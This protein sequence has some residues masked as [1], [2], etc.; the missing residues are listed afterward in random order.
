MSSKLPNLTGQFE[1]KGYWWLPENPEKK[2]PGILR[3]SQELINLE[4][5]GVFESDANRLRQQNQPIILGMSSK[6]GEITLHR[7][8]NLGFEESIPG[9]ITTNFSIMQLFVGKNFSNPDEITFRNITIQYFQLDDWLGI[10]GLDTDISGGKFSA[11]YTI[12]PSIIAKI[13]DEFGISIGFN[14]EF[15]FN[16]VGPR[17]VGLEQAAAITVEAIKETKFDEFNQF[18]H[19]LR[20]FF[21]LCTMGAEYPISLKGQTEQAKIQGP[22]GEI[23][24]D[25]IIYY[26]LNDPPEKLIQKINVDMLLL[27]HDIN[28]NFESYLRNWFLKKDTLEPVF[29]LYF[30]TLYNPRMYTDHKFLSLIQA[31]ESYH[32][33]TMK[34]YV[35]SNED[36]QTRINDILSS[37]Q[38]YKDWLEWRLRY[39]NEPSL[40]KRLTELFKTFEYILSETSGYNSELIENIVNTRNYLTHFDSKLKDKASSG[41]VLFKIILK[42]LPILETV[43]LFELGLPK[44]KIKSVIEKSFLKK[45]IND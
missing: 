44:D 14:F 21:T 33:R 27:Y 2:I 26:R 31:I 7:C 4:L 35:M 15:N 10:S 37:N 34:N 23:M 42:M 3:Y 39:A 29:N 38:Q 16:H 1:L 17:K 32:R 5:F 11:S 41:I 40:Q 28:D 30:A 20:N 13:T 22:D 24:K 25:I 6:F 43:L 45:K 36:F 8:F 18:L 19:H 9:F 12:P